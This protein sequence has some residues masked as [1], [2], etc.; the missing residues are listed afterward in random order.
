MSERKR[1]QNSAVSPAA[2]AVI[3]TCVNEVAQAYAALRMPVFRLA[4]D[5]SREH[6]TQLERLFNKPAPQIKPDPETQIK[7]FTW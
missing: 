5:G 4:E 2:R 1:I 3:L 7:V 6:D